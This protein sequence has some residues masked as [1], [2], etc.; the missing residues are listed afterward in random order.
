MQKQH[1]GVDVGNLTTKK[2]GVLRKILIGLNKQKY[3]IDIEHIETVL[4]KVVRKTFNN[5]MPCLVEGILNG[6]FSHLTPQAKSMIGK[7][8][9]ISELREK[10][11]YRI[12]G[13]RKKMDIIKP[14]LVK[15][16][17]I[18][19]CRYDFFIDWHLSCADMATCLQEELDK[20][21]KT[22]DKSLEK[23]S[24]VWKVARNVYDECKFTKH[25]LEKVENELHF[26]LNEQKVKIP[27]EWVNSTFDQNKKVP[28]DIKT[29]NNGRRNAVRC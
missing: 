29:N 5:D 27:V 18:Y 16:I 17:P 14:F 25:V 9:K 1:Q 26:F 21:Y 24:Q 3:P 6:D 7:K 15:N 12:E 13:F 11:K 4:Q 23:L 2:R 28:I 8:I 22:P 10:Q 19:Y 20:V